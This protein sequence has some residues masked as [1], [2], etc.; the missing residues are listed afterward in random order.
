MSFILLRIFLAYIKLDIFVTEPKL[1][2]RAS[3]TVWYC[4]YQPT[5]SELGQVISSESKLDPDNLNQNVDID[6]FDMVNFGSV[7][8]DNLNGMN[9]VWNVSKFSWAIISFE[10]LD[11]LITIQMPYSTRCGYEQILSV[12]QIHS[13]FSNCVP[14]WRPVQRVRRVRGRMIP[15]MIPI[16]LWTR[17]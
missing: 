8:V 15:V 6:L 17:S 5:I 11:N 7:Q 1:T 10:Y 13:N 12:I 2:G 9:M 16:F 3:W 14:D 4:P